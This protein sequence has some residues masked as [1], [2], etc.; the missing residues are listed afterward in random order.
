MDIQFKNGKAFI[1][2]V[3][4]KNITESFSTPIYLYSQKIIEDTYRNLNKNLSAEIF[5]AVKA[6]SNQAILTL[7][8][9]CGAGADVVSAG[10]LERALQ[11]GFNPDKNYI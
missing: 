8:K 1:E 9:N 6:N 10:E 3:E 2:E 5:F 7:M 11:A 4:L